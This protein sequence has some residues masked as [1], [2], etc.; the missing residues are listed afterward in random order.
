MDAIRL[1]ILSQLVDA[2]KSRVNELSSN[3]LLQLILE[4]AQLAVDLFPSLVTQVV[5]GRRPSDESNHNDSSNSTHG[6]NCNNFSGNNTTTGN[7][8]VETS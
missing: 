6:N 5:N 3:Q 1:F 7:H 8:A 4:R 2:V